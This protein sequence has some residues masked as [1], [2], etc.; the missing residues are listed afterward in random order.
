V[1]VLINLYLN[2]GI[3]DLKCMRLILAANYVQLSPVGEDQARGTVYG[4]SFARLQVNLK[5]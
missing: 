3:F 1:A 5:L 4:H 2:S